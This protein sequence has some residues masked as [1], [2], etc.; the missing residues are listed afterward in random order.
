MKKKL[1]KRRSSKSVNKNVIDIATR[2][3]IL[4]RSSGKQPGGRKDAPVGRGEIRMTAYLSKLR[5]R[6]EI[7][8]ILATHALEHALADLEGPF[9]GI[10]R[11][12]PVD[13]IDAAQAKMAEALEIL[14]PALPE[15]E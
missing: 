13:L 11:D 14:V 5:A 8:H 10:R 9:H 6:R 2:S 3:P 12:I 1:T 15:D 4:K 7:V